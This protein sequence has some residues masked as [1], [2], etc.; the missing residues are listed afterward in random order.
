MSE[1]QRHSSLRTQV[2]HWLERPERSARSPWLLETALVVL[3]CLNVGAVILETVDSIYLRWQIAFNLF[4]G[5]SLLVFMIEYL[6]RLWVAPENPDT[7]SPFNNSP[8][9]SVPRQKNYF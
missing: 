7:R 5:F 2:Y 3:I 1:A 6:A 4:E 9:K 8:I